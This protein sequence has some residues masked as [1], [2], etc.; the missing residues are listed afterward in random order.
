M[1]SRFRQPRI[2]IA[3]ACTLIVATLAYL[4]GWS[5]VFH[6][7]RYSIHGLPPQ[8]R[9]IVITQ[10]EENSLV[11]VGTPMAR[12][13]SRVVA[14]AL[15]RN[16]W[17]SRVHISRHWLSGEIEI[18]LSLARPIA[19]VASASNTYLVD[20]GAIVRFPD[21]FTL[22]LPEITGSYLTSSPSAAAHMAGKFLA[23][24][25]RAS[26]SRVEINTLAI[27]GPSSLST[28]G[29]IGAETPDLAHSLTIRWGSTDDIPLK[30]KVLQG[31]LALP[32]NA[33]IVSV[34]LSTPLSP[35]VK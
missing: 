8:A 33:K 25:S 15:S 1:S 10:I 4:L 23:E 18:S 14:R 6:V 35:I 19:R 7:T 21:S 29:V 20:S 2:F 34:D 26:K 9:S 17:I 31:L 13:D 30:I 11:K 16:E 28:T 32:E 12:T 22:P 24:L 3:V 5:H 27:N